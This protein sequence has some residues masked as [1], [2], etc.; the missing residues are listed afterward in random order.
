MA[1]DDRASRLKG[2][3]QRK[4]NDGGRARL[5]KADKKTP[6][7]KLA[8]LKSSAGIV[9]PEIKK[10]VL[11]QHARN[12]ERTARRSNSIFPSEMARSEWCPRSTYYRMYGLPEPS[13]SYSFGLDNVFA[14]GNAIHEKWQGWLAKTGHLW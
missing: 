3:G 9:V 5:V 14:E 8:E 6:I 12:A 7:G 13:S 10:V 4:V 1:M 11:A 2:A